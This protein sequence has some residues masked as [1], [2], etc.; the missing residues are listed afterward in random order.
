MRCLRVIYLDC[1]W[2][3]IDC[4]YC[5]PCLEMRASSPHASA[6]TVQLWAYA[7]DTTHETA[8]CTSKVVTDIS[9]KIV[10]QACAVRCADAGSGSNFDRRMVDTCLSTNPSRRCDS[11]VWLLQNYMFCWCFATS[12]VRK[13]GRL[14]G[15]HFT[16]H[17]NTSNK[18]W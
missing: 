4:G 7:S 1:V 18:M 11:A 17:T 13:M 2:L 9:C 16:M 3:V 10:H 12:C 5:C 15:S 6:M 8:S 14:H